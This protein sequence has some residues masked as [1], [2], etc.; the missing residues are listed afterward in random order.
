MISAISSIIQLT[1]DLD[2][3]DT[4]FWFQF[5]F[6]FKGWVLR[7]YL[8]LYL[9]V[10]NVTKHRTFHFQPPGRSDLL[11]SDLPLQQALPYPLS[12]EGYQ[13]STSR[14]AEEHHRWCSGWSKF[15]MV[16]KAWPPGF[17]WEMKLYGYPLLKI[18][19]IPVVTTAC[20]FRGAIPK[21]DQW[22][23][24]RNPNVLIDTKSRAE[25]P[26][27]TRS[28]LLF[29]GFWT[30]EVIFILDL[31]ISISE[32]LEKEE[33]FH[34]LCSL[35]LWQNFFLSLKKSKQLKSW[36]FGFF[37]T[38][39]I[40]RSV[41]KNFHH[42]PS[43]GISKGPMAFSTTTTRPIYFF[44][45]LKRKAVVKK[46]CV[47]IIPSFLVALKK[48]KTAGNRCSAVSGKT[49]VAWIGRR[50]PEGEAYVKA[51]QDRAEGWNIGSKGLW[52]M[53]HPKHICWHYHD[54][55]F[56]QGIWW[57]SLRIYIYIHTYE[58]HMYIYIFIHTRTCCSL[59]MYLLVYPVHSKLAFSNLEGP[60]LALPV[61][62]KLAFFIW[63][64]SS[65]L[66]FQGSFKIT[67]IFGDQTWCSFF[68]G[69]FWMIS[70]IIHCLG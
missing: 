64:V 63:A 14:G 43:E 37:L 61:R 58:F 36:T 54:Y 59:S 24:R 3:L 65:A 68:F 18:V 11:R 30:P 48:Q 55:D 47:Y 62:K 12:T 33:I 10:A 13:P 21:P 27:Q 39:E 7:P 50:L 22:S 1:E 51:G 56:I 46:N 23:K 60:V 35:G 70:L 9:V 45:T 29:H 16:D 41:T 40:D 57:Y 52:C 6:F 34:K 4:S 5:P 17:K 25:P 69:D 42:F 8:W 32:A 31:W 49:L 28:F 20:C 2:F 53:K 15:L 66:I 26:R 38:S 44:R 19:A 67:N